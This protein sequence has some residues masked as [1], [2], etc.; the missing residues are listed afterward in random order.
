MPHFDELPAD[1]K[2]VLQLLLKQGKT[3]DDIAGL[4]RLDR[5]A[6]RERA[7]DALD[8]MGPDDAG[9]LSGERQDE[10]SDHLLLQQTASERA[11][12]RS[13]L[14]GSAAGR[15]WAR[16]VASELKP[17]GG[18]ALPEIPADPAEVEEA[19][20]A[21]SARREARDRQ[22]S[23]SRLGGLLLIGAVVAVVAIGLFFLLKDDDETDTSASGT[24]PTVSDGATGPGGALPDQQINLVS[25]VE[26][27]KAL[28]LALVSQGGLALQAQGL[29]KS[30][31]YAVWLYTSADQALF[32]GFA[33][34]DT[35]SKRVF[36]ALESLPAEA[37]GFKEL[38]VTRE[39]VNEPSKPGTIVLR[40]ALKTS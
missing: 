17:V 19:F 8:A 5:Q 1:Q 21:L 33:R 27:S 9:G 35:Q 22:A 11:A 7:L 30:N 10:I 29:Q 14:E 34:Y 31:R 28:G 32:Q 12:T 20:G 16:H 3:Y 23:S 18:D 36:G 2:A 39:T 4:L 38:I 6:V 37:K 26:G 15:S 25:A 40:G 24:Q 13:F